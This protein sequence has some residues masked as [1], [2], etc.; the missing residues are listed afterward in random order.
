MS[1]EPN[2]TKLAVLTVS[3]KILEAGQKQFSN[4]P[5]RSGV[6]VYSLKSDSLLGLTVKYVGPMLS[7]KTQEVHFS[8][9]GNILC[10][11]DQDGIN[12]TSLN[13]FLIQKI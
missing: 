6:D 9:A 5:N 8:G 11:I 1:W 12:K 10:T 3:K 7:D 13:F 2:G 4:D